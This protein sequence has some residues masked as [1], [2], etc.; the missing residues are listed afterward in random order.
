MFNIYVS[1]DSH[2]DSSILIFP[3]LRGASATELRGS[4]TSQRIAPGRESAKSSS[5]SHLRDRGPHRREFVTVKSHSLDAT[6]AQHDSGG[7]VQQVS[8][9][10]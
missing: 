3:Q 8:L 1:S 7:S 9:H 5:I 10:F 4:R 2:G 6:P